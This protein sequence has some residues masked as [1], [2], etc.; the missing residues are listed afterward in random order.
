MFNQR[1]IGETVEGNRE[2]LIC[3]NPAGGS[4]Q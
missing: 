4:R 3:G 1:S 2:T